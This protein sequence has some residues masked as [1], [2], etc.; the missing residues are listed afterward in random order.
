MK[1]MSLMGLTFVVVLSA[2]STAVQPAT[3]VTPPKVESIVT[4]AG[5]LPIT[6]EKTTLKVLV[7]GR[8]N[9]DFATSSA[10]KWVEE[11]TNI[12]IEWQVAPEGP[13]SPV[14][15][16][17]VLASGDYPDVIMNFHVTSAQQLNYGKQGVFIPL[18]KLIDQYGPNTKKYVFDA[19]P[20]TKDDITAPDGNIYSLPIVNDCYQCSMGQ[21]FWLY[22]PWMDKLGLKMPTTP[23]ELY[24]VLKA[25][26]EK[27]PNGNGKAD[28][29]PLSGSIQGNHTGLDEF[30]MNAFVLNPTLNTT[31]GFSIDDAQHMYVN[32]G[33][34]T[35]SFTQPGWKEGLKFLN[36]LYAEKLIDPQAFTQNLK[37][38]KALGENPNIPIMGSSSSLGTGQIT[39]YGGPSNRWS[40]Y[41]AVPPLK[42]PSGLQVAPYT[43]SATSTGEFI[44]TKAAKHPEVA[45]RLADFLYD[46]DVTWRLQKGGEGL[47][48]RKPLPGEMGANGKPAEFATLAPIAEE[49]SNNNWLQRGLFA[50][51]DSQRY[52]SAIDPKAPKP[53]PLILFEATK[54]L[55]EPYKQKPDT[56]IPMLFMEAD[57]GKQV[58]DHS[59]TIGT[60]VEEMF[61]RF[62]TGDMDID[63]GWDAYLSQLKSMNLDKLVAIYQTAYD[64]KKKK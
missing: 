19:F 21:K 2:C 38:L 7:E 63:K 28:E 32:N 29:I 12:H 26:K 27:D 48:W 52:T 31:S 33:K 45:M 10:T 51:P 57:Q 50:T 16:N 61:A 24:N 11:Q 42:G 17:V 3:S 30:I 43:P 54:D 62:V 55:Y 1:K 25:F 40:E 23:D 20:A 8:P 59:K 41:V 46:P 39:Q 58:V 9:I 36:K 53:L 15:L 49:K 47:N 44:I 60:Y 37:Q 4:P 34:I 13:E 56:L 64:A 18:N 35:P 14:K 22:K 6:K 5:T